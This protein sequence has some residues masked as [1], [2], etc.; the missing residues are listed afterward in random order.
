MSF[1]TRKTFIHLQKNKLFIRDIDV[2]TFST[3]EI[4]GSSIANATWYDIFHL[5]NT[6]F[7]SVRKCPNVIRVLDDFS[8]S[9]F[10]AFEVD[11]LQRGESRP[12]DA[13]S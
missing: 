12:W 3:V 13:L 6:K 1:Q 2:W 8:S 4:L 9:A 10:A 5:M 11:V 7:L